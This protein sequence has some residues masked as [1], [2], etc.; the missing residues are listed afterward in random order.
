M[1][2]VDTFLEKVRTARDALEPDALIQL[3]EAVLD[4]D[5]L[6]GLR[7]HTQLEAVNRVAKGVRFIMEAGS[8]VANPLKAAT[9]L[10]LEE[11]FDA[12]VAERWN[13][14]F[15]PPPDRK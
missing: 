2:G 9:Q 13:Q 3:R 15:Q 12:T 7:V 11:L 1:W 5:G 14:R 4:R 8:V 10:A 6:R